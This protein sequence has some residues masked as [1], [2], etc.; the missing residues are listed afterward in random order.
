MT[1]DIEADLPI[2]TKLMYGGTATSLYALS[3]LA[4]NPITFYY[5]VKLGLSAELIGIAWLIFAIWNAINDPLFG[6][7]E[8]RTKSK[9]GRR[10]P[11]L[12]YGAPLYGLFFIFM[13]IPLVD[14]SNELALFL[15]FLITLIIFDTMYTLIVLAN[16]A[17]GLE[18]AFTSSKRAKLNVIVNIMLA[19][20]TG[21]GF[22]IP[23]LFLTGD[24]STR[25]N[26]FLIPAIIIIGI[27]CSL[28]IFISSY[29]LKENKYIQMEQPLAFVEGI[30]ETLKN[31]PFVIHTTALFAITLA[32]TIILTGIFYYVEFVLVLKGLLVTFPLL[33]MF[34][35]VIMFSV[36]YL[37]KLVVKY[38]VRN[39]YIFGLLQAAFTFFLLFLFGMNIIA[40][41]FIFMLIGVGFGIMSTLNG[42]IGGEV[43]DFDE[44]S[45][46]KRRETTYGGIS[47]LFIKP[48]IS[49]ANW[50]FL[51]IINYYGFKAGTSAKE[52]SSEALFGVMVAFG[53][54]PAIFLVFAAI[55]M[56]LFPL[57]GPD[58]EQKKMEIKLIHDQKEKEFIE[59]FKT[60][61]YE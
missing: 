40:A 54:L 22:L 50:L 16:G 52:Q 6:L 26:S 47:S 21:V 29:V 31:K 10:L 8:D 23:L 57:N 55:I 13:W 48:S 15:N 12:R 30:K 41:F 3:N 7:F 43:I 39:V 33:L 2:K 51:L 56:M 61:K 19:L 49:I 25:I 20:G 34:G 24:D 36:F 35:V 18:I 37:N 14:I 32:N 1:E 45:T 59:K 27:T 46:G 38:G 44:L 28:T 17:L 11:Y 4:F 5:N 42:V 58:W 9:I 53:L 60:K